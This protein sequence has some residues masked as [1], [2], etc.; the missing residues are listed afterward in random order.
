MPY[1]IQPSVL[2]F[3]FAE[4]HTPPI[5][6]IEDESVFIADDKADDVQV[7]LLVVMDR[8]GLSYRAM[9]EIISLTK[10]QPDMKDIRNVEDVLQRSNL[11]EKHKIQLCARCFSVIVD[12]KCSESDW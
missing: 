6:D 8:H 7:A 5:P 9:N 10:K 3:H 2:S 1:T 12:H 4:Q 11:P